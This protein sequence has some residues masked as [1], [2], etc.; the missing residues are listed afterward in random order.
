MRRYWEHEGN[1]G[2]VVEHRIARYPNAPPTFW[3]GPNRGW[4]TTS[5]SLEECVVFDTKRE[6]LEAMRSVG[7][8]GKTKNPVRLSEVLQR[9]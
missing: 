6:A 7:Y 5:G 9:T 4:G 2:W 3:F 8:R 1:G